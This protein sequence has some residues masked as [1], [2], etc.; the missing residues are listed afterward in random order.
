MVSAGAGPFGHASS[1]A[2]PA[3]ADTT[4]PG[5][6]PPEVRAGTA[7]LVGAF[8]TSAS[9][10][11]DV[12]LPYRNQA[13]LQAYIANQASQGIYLTHEQF[14]AQFAPTVDQINAV[15][16]W[17]A[18]H[19]LSSTYTSA[20]G[21]TITLQGTT[22]AIEHALSVQMNRYRS[23]RHGSYF[24]A[25]ADPV[26]PANL[27]ISAVTGLNSMVR[28]HV[29]SSA[30]S[31]PSNGYTP[32]ELRSIYDVGSSYD[33]T[34]QAI[35]FTLWGEALRNSDLTGFAS[36]T[37]DTPMS[38]QVVST[39]SS[40]GADTIDWVYAN[41]ADS[42]TDAWDETAM[43]VE[44][45]HG[46]APH[47]HLV[48]YLGNEICDI[49]G[50]GGS[51]VGLEN[52]ISMAVNN[53]AVHV[54]SNSWGGTEETSPLDAFGTALEN[55]FLQAAAEGTTFYFSSGDAG[56]DSGGTGLPSYPADSPYVVSVGGTTLSTT[57]SSTYAGET[58]WNVSGSGGG[59]AGC[60]AV[61]AKPS[62]QNGVSTGCSGRAEPDVS[63]DSDPS[64]GADVY[65]NGA[66]EVVGGTSLAAPLWAGMAAAADR[67]AAVNG[68]SRIGWANPKIYALAASATKYASDFHDVT[69]GTT[70]GSIAYGAGTGWD[71]ATGWGSID[72][73]HYVCDIV[74]TS[75][76]CSGSSSNTA[77][78]TSTPVPPTAT[79]TNTPLPTATKTNT[80][81]PTATK[82]NTPLPTATK[83]NTPLPTA[84]KANTPLPTATKT[85]TP[86]P[87]ATKTNTPL[88]TAT[89]TSTPVSPAPTRTSTPV[90]T[91]CASDGTCLTG[92]T[93]SA[94]SASVNT[95]VTLT[96]NA[97]RNVGPT[98]W[99][100]DIV[101]ESGTILGACA[102]GT[103]CALSVTSGTAASHQYTAW[104]STS[105]TS[106]A[107]G[108]SHTSSVTVTWTG[109]SATATSTPTGSGSCASDGTCLKGLTAS[110]TSP[111]V[112]SSVTLTASTSKDVG[113]TIWYIDIVNE[114]GTILT[115]CGVGSSC[116]AGVSS[117]TATSHQYKAWLSTSGTSIAGGGPSSS[118]VT[119]TWH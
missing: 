48:Y 8:D 119:V 18:Q 9:L 111:S 109:S 92:L 62:Y 101:N 61:L 22:A 65:V 98:V 30:A 102:S 107:G 72:W 15:K 11:I 40:S 82:T 31:R 73:S 88:P 96:A 55:D 114:S 85:N 67:Y 43:D 37:G 5:E 34:N 115:S 87:T 78:P 45:A 17:A 7:Q 66:N 21:T 105:S 49:T 38:G 27:G 70:Y 1:R 60:S 36:A 74:G 79:K 50:C 41:G 57:G 116:S 104:L 91:G 71:R 25:S 77:T 53:S 39:P 10:T 52:A 13:A 95:S 19:G 99:Y 42:H 14:Y 110:S 58:T 4:V 84:T 23:A 103:S 2:A 16:A 94:T 3:A 44:Y 56:S 86:L 108:G 29:M 68:L 33:G 89:R 26:V 81:L 83:T 100:I 64:T 93:A 59:G 118:S 69:S 35:A 90:S 47:S 6:T 51:E 117:S 97:N 20:D 32:A 80:P 106:I 113:P 46:M 28:F 54:V 12:T 63:A 76:G 75:S 112:S 24:S